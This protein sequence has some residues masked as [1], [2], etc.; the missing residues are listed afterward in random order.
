MKDCG[1]Y[2]ENILLYLDKQLSVSHVIEFR[3]H[4]EICG[5]CVGRC[6]RRKKNYPASYIDRAPFIPSRLSSE[7]ASCE[8]LKGPAQRI[9]LDGDEIARKSKAVVTGV[10]RPGE[11]LDS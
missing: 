4:L 8:Q 5:A 6:S 2:R 3:A 10:E 11:P 1:D 9:Y 7:I